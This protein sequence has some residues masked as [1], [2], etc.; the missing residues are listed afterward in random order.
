[1]LDYFGRIHHLNYVVQRNF[2]GLP[3]NLPLMD[4]LDL[5]VSNDDYDEL[6]SQ[7]EDFPV[8]V[9]IR[10]PGDGYYPFI[11]GDELLKDRRELRGIWIPSPEAYFIS[12]Y[13]HANVQG[14]EEK[15]RKELKRAFLEWIPPVEPEDKGVI[16]DIT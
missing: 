8:K 2:D 15:Y 5:Y 11:I 1:M 9:D 3:Y 6:R 14:R 4:D 13:Y 16:C 10:T 7:T 12:L